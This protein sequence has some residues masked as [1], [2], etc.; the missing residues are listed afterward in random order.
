MTK[1][2]LEITGESPYDFDGEILYSGNN[3]F[4]KGKEQNRFHSIDIYKS[5]DE[6]GLFF[7]IYICYKTLWKGEQNHYFEA[8]VDTEQ[9]LVKVLDTYNPIAYLLGYPPGPQFAEKQSRLKKSLTTNWLDLKTKAISALNLKRQARRGNPGHPLG[10]CKNPGWSIP[11]KIREIVSNR[12]KET[13]DPESAIVTS[14]LAI[15]FS[16]PMP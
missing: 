13:G 3:L 12:A 8:E 10:P 5:E 4:Q 1:F 15:Y 2:V 6:E 9:D 7:V 14:A 16:L 11:E